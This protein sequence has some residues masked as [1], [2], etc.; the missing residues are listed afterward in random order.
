MRYSMKWGPEAIWFLVV[1]G[2]TY[3]LTVTADLDFT[4]EDLDWRKI[5][6]AAGAGLI[7]ALIGGL[8]S[9]AGKPP[10]DQSEPPVPPPPWDRTR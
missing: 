7:R 2:F 8:I 9:L 1:T 5:A 10:E 6:V 4:A 3:L